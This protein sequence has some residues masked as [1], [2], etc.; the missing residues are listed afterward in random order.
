MRFLKAVL[1]LSVCLAVAACEEQQAAAP[2]QPVRA[3]KSF[4]VSKRAGEQVR[5]IAGVTEAAKVTDLAFESGGKIVALS[6]DIGDK[7]EA[8]QVVARLDPE[9]FDL[10]VLSS[11]AQ[12]K[13]AQSRLTDA[14]TKF[15]QQRQLYEQGYAAKTA[16]DSALATKQSAES[17]LEIAQ[18]EL[19]QAR[20]N[21]SETDLRSPLAGVISAKHVEQFTEVTAGQPVVELSADGDIKVNS[22]V[23]EGLVRRLKLAQPVLVRFPT[24]ND[25]IA[26]G[27]ITQIGASA[28]STNSFPVT[29]VLG[30]NDLSLRPGLTAEVMFGFETD[31]TGKAFL[32]PLAA[33]LPSGTDGKGF[34][35]RFNGDAG[36]VNRVPVDILNIRD[37]DLEV[38]GGLEAGDIVAAAGISFLSDG[39]QVKLMQQGRN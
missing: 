31:A 27:T 6:V 16:Y 24:L 34:V 25:E 18:S 26:E 39:M 33:V 3:I 36:V 37:N 23:P 17:A 32:L 4:T 1:A 10:R 21:R 11:Q 7:V 15:G 20:R 8:G 9:P 29:V 2:E 12:V 5:Q 13:D 22:S 19:R 38:T 30:S 28:S 35:F 14:Q